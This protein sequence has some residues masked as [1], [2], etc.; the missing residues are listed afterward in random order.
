MKGLVVIFLI[1]SLILVGCSPSPVVEP[2]DVEIEM[3]GNI[4][5]T[6]VDYTTT[7]KTS[8]GFSPG[9]Y[10]IDNFSAGKQADLPIM[11][12]NGGDEPCT[13]AITYR[14]P[15]F[16]E[17]GYVRAP[18]E[19]VGWLVIQEAYLELKPKEKKEILVT[20]DMPE[21]AEIEGNW[22]FWVAIKDASQTGMVQTE[23]C[24]RVFVNMLQ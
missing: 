14:N 10:T 20:L 13:L 18:V 7:E 23:G 6:P 12:H 24:V 17:E 8:V 1:G 11:L 9:K 3:E 4:Y 19:V 2:T 5:A 15:D 21:G 22:E 16:I